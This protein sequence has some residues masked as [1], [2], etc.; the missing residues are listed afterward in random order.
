MLASAVVGCGPAD[1]AATQ[2][3][4]VEEGGSVG[5]LFDKL[6]DF[7]GDKSKQDK[8]V[9]AHEPFVPPP[10]GTDPAV[11][12]L[13]ATMGLVEVEPD[14]NASLDGALVATYAYEADPDDE[15][16]FDEDVCFFSVPTDGKPS[17]E[18]LFWA[19]MY[20][21][22][23]DN[24]EVSDTQG[25]PIGMEVVGGANEGGGE[26]RVIYYV[27]GIRTDW[28]THCETLQLIANLTGGVA[29]GVLNETEGMAKDIWQTA[30]DRFTITVERKLEE[31]GFDKI[32]SIH[33]N[34]AATVLMN[35]IIQRI[36][37]GKTVELWAHSQGG[38]VTSLALQRAIRTLRAEG[39][40]PV[41]VDGQEKT[42]AIRVVTFGSAS[43][44]WQG[45]WPEGPTYEHFV[46]L[47]DATPSTLGVGAF[48]GFLA[49]GKPRAGDNAKM[50]F[51]DGEPP[52]DEYEPSSFAEQDPETAEVGFLDL[53]PQRY[54]GVDGVYFKMFEQAYGAWV[55]REF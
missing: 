27:N 34:A 39:R 1:D 53:D 2:T 12:E 54:H 11:E 49:L 43:P 4:N 51:F 22:R 25:N 10:P 14:P 36:R 8:P 18:M 17:V 40:F 33:D 29:I 46:H 50:R 3:S 30:W 52:E 24:G 13:F 23:A 41:V 21:F 37:E 26:T 38:A 16:D 15:E 55:D 19:E 31:Y 47:R 7:F 35:V 5:R 45:L 32:Q 6:T 48:G 20:G 44:K 42:D 28:D 9:A